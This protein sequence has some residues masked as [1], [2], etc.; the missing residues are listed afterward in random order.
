MPILFRTLIILLFTFLYSVSFAQKTDS[1]YIGIVKGIARDSVYNFALQSATIAVYKTNDSSL[2]GYRLS[3]NLGEFEMESLPVGVS[4]KIVISN[5][6]YKSFNK[7]FTIPPG[8]KEI[9]LKVLNLDRAASELDEVVIDYVPPVRMNGDTLEF[10][11]GAFKLDKNAVVEDLLRKLPGITVWGDGAITVNGKTVS[12]VL[13]DGKPFFGGDPKVA[14]QNLPKD[15]VDKIQVYQQNQ[16]EQNPMDSVTEVNIKLKK[17]KRSGMFGKVGLG[18]GTRDRFEADGSLNLFS[19]K[20]QVGIIGASN[21][22]NKSAQSAGMMMRNNTFKGAGLSLDFLPNFRASG[23]NQPN[24]G[25]ISFQ[26]D[27][28]ADPKWQKQERLSANYFIKNNNNTVIRNTLTTTQLGDNN[29][30][31]RENNSAS[32]S[33]NTGHD[34]DSK[35]EKQTDKFSFDISP[36]VAI[37][38]STNNSEQ[39]SSTAN[40]LGELQST[41]NSVSS[42]NN[43]SKTL[44]LN[45]G[46]STR[47][48][49]R[50]FNRWPQGFRINYSLDAGETNSKQ[51]NLSEFVSLINPA[52]NK[53]TDRKYDNRSTYVNHSLNINNVDV[54]KLIFGYQNL[55]GIEINLENNL[56]F[57]AREDD[58]LIADLENVSNKYISNAYLTNKSTLQTFNERP[59]LNFRKNFQKGLVNRYSKDVSIEFK[60]QG[61][62]YNQKNVSEHGF[63]NISRSYQRF[64]PNAN[65]RYHNRQYG[66]YETTFSLGFDASAAYPNINQLAPLVDSSN[67]YNI[68]VGNLNLGV[69]DRRELKLGIDHNNLR[70]KN[71]FSY[72]IDFSVGYLNNAIVD[73]SITDNLGRS[74]QY[75]VNADGNKYANASGNINKAFKFNKNQLQFRVNTSF[76]LSQNPNYVNNVLNLSKNFNNNNTVSLFYTLKEFLTLN[77]NQGFSFYQ[78]KQ[79]GFNNN[80]FTNS[81]RS[82]SFSGMGNFTKNISLTS[83]I[84]YNISSSSASKDVEFVIWNAS[85]NLRFLKGNNAELKVSALDILHQNTSIINTGSNN[86]ITLGTVNVLQNYYMVTFSY[87]PRK[88]GNSPRIRGR[89]R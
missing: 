19:P 82:T 74:R 35:Y 42:R 39:Y 53:V 7:I 47:R 58:N 13:V 65:I 54:K 50:E 41:N 81:S 15:A 30:I 29:Q 16:D 2:I 59:S 45:T 85:A 57:N 64:L 79:S 51:S 48:N 62:F 5:T 31:I 43:E 63:Q 37:D 49:Q 56:S 68:R 88:F 1:T 89:M 9:D 76:G 87:Y 26:H 80:E 6:G 78:S 11:A 20:N 55:A 70:A 8:K 84:D 36:S 83:N 66:D 21:N 46:F 71:S 3:N 44:K 27:F 34:F 40:E 23:I 28:I 60:A 33:I 67:L 69:S 72:G 4:L 12:S 52:D 38:N 17:N 86:S 22:I 18:Y 61:Q 24:S 25:G 77:L 73:S 10:N 75:M 32:N 14:I